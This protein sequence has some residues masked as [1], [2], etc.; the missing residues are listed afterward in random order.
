MSSPHGTP[1][2]RRPVS[3]LLRSCAAALALLLPVAATTGC[4]RK[5]VDPAAA[6]REKLRAANQSLTADDFLKAAAGGDADRVA[7][8]LRAGLDRN[9]AD[10]RGRTPLMAA[11]EAGKVNVVKLLLDEN[12]NP[13]LADRDGATALTLA[14]AAGQADV[15][16]RLVE[17]N[18]DVT[19]RDKKNWTALMRAVFPGHKPVV[20]VLLATSRDRLQRDGQLDRALSV[21]A[22]L[23]H[24]AILK[25]LLDKGANV[26][27][28]LDGGR[29][30][31]MCAAD[32]GKAATVTLLLSRG[33]D[34][35]LA[36]AEGSTAGILAMQ[37]GF[38][39]VSRMLDAA[40]QGLPVPAPGAVAAS[41][42]PAPEDVARAQ[43]EATDAAG[44]AMEQAYLQQKNID[45]K[46][47]L[48]RDAGQDSDGDGFTDDEELAAGTDPNN[49]ASHPP[50]ATRLRMR[51]V[52]GEAFPALFDGID[53]RTGK[54]RLSV[55][56]DHQR[57]ELA[58]GDRL[59]D[60][61][62]RVADIRRRRVAV[63]DSAEMVDA[64]EV[65]LTQ[66]TTGQKV[67]LVRA[68]PTN[69]PD[70]RA[71]LALDLAN[72]QGGERE[73]RL[74]EEFALPAD[75]ATRYKVLDIRPAQVVLKV[76]PNGGTVT[77]N[78]APPPAPGNEE[79]SGK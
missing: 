36:N 17:A 14:A 51:K 38:N 1:D 78:L 9:G 31:L 27:A 60:L 72:G 2:A 53:T 21:A 19:L 68:M 74:G 61:P 5:P 11:A 6:A 69:S 59:P 16:R 33:A 4:K 62:W 47:L 64:S 65:T 50:F 76:L 67:T 8:F 35:K 79:K 15:V 66:V 20:D 32:A 22:Y 37:R 77:V 18:A 28:K 56:R 48:G 71:L 12:A 58:E 55:G 57:A 44:G 40:A 43:Q 39:D 34:A 73:V 13:N 63:K 29:T 52:E 7:L 24:D 30:A 25:A 3:L 45:P 49:P 75:P 54:A 46:A 10:A 42:E 41:Q 26:N 23:G 70:S